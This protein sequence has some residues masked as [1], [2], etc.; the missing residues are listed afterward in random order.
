MMAEEFLPPPWSLDEVKSRMPKEVFEHRPARALVV[1]ARDISLAILFGS[2]IVTVRSLI[3]AEMRK[4]ESDLARVFCRVFLAISWSLYWWFQGLVFTGIWVIGHE[5][6]HESFLPSKVACQVLGLLTHSFLWTPHFGWKHVHNLHHRYHGLMEDDQHWIPKTRAQ[7][8]ET[9]Q[10]T[11]IVNLARLVVQQVI[12]FPL[13]LLFHATGPRHY[14]WWTNHFNPFSF[15]YHGHRISI[16]VSDISLVLVAYLT[17]RASGIFGVWNIVFLYA[18]PCLIVS[19]WVTMIVYLHHT[20]VRVPHYRRP[21][22]NY[23]RGA[24][25]TIDRD[26]LGW[27]GRFFLH[28]I[29][30]FHVVHHLFPRMPFYHG[31][32]ATKYLKAV[33]GSDYRM[34]NTPVFKG[35]W[36]TYSACQFVED[37]GDILFYK[38]NIK[39][40]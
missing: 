29:A 24:L 22:W 12:G 9:L 10:D 39:D 33:I 20:D 13:Y 2:V 5:C 8:G 36:E 16:V 31:E 23:V 3:A 21:A 11:P 32:T 1:L 15:F 27:Q 40:L 25:A 38:R 35:L 37:N 7:I 19:H 18:I 4:V 6:A 14:P 30:H 28:D 26:F 17:R 34:V